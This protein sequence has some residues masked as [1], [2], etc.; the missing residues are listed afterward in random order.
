M[1][2][3]RLCRELTEWDNLYLSGRLQKP[4]VTL[5][6]CPRVEVFFFFPA[7]I[8]FWPIRLR[9]YSVARD[10]CVRRRQRAATSSASKAASQTE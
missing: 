2:R 7:V 4:V 8:F 9:I 10:G 3:G 6:A 1:E 5:V